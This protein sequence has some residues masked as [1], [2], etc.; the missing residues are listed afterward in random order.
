MYVFH[1]GKTVSLVKFEVALYG[2][3]LLYGILGYFHIIL[4]DMIFLYSSL[5]VAYVTFLF[6]DFK[7]YILF[8]CIL[9][10]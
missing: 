8:A 5:R 6:I 3:A 10:L 1:F 4:V 7:F 9:V 2:I